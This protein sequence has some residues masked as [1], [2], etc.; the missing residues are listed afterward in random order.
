MNE[1]KQIQTEE[2]VHFRP[3]SLKSFWTLCYVE[4]ISV[5]STSGRLPI[6]TVES[7]SPFVGVPKRLNGLPS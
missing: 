6:Q 4:T 5:G 2:K 1:S 7:Q 3:P